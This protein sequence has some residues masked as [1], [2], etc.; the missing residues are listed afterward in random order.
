MSSV[1]S[2]AAIFLDRDGT[3]IREVG[4]LSRPEQVEILPGVGEA[5]RGLRDLGFKLV[6]V[7]NQ[8]AVARGYLSERELAVIHALLRE[9]LAAE[10]VV[11]DAIYY[12]PHHPT[13]GLGD[14]RVACNC[15]KPNPGMVH[16][17]VEELDLN[18]AAS[19]LIGD[20]MTDMQLAEIVGATGLLLG[21]ALAASPASRGEVPAFADL[22]H[23]GQWIAAR[24]R[25]MAEGMERR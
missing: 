5:L 22:W 25:R 9:R 12:C 14:Y 13:E 21:D 23:A 11:L 20:Q 19:Y 1:T 3:L 4:H 18:A 15:R 7:T 8:S 6:V 24:E 2:G 17:A 16:Q 10:R